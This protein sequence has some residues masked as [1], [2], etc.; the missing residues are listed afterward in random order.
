MIY[1]GIYS[2]RPGTRA[3]KHLPDNISKEMK[4]ERRNQLNNLLKEISKHN[5]VTEV[6][7]SHT[8]IIDSEDDKNYFGYTENMKQISIKKTDQTFKIGEFIDVKIT[9]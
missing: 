3:H 8:M 2:P 5:N 6:G 1:I 9:H 4:R 7:R